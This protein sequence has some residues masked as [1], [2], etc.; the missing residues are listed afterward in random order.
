MITEPFLIYDVL[1]YSILVVHCFIRYHDLWFKHNTRTIVIGSV[2]NGLNCRLCLQLIVQ[3][4][5]FKFSL[6]RAFVYSSVKA[7]EAY[8]ASRPV[9]GGSDPA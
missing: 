5:D 6:V 4:P 2:I 7:R 3:L 9:I 8:G 1:D